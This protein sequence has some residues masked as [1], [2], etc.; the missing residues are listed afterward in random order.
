MDRNKNSVATGA[1]KKEH[2][3]RVKHQ[4]N[5]YYSQTMRSLS[6]KLKLIEMMGGGCSKCGYKTNVSALHFHHKD[7]TEKE[8]KLDMRVLSNRRWEVILAEA[9]KCE[10]LC[11]NCHAEVHNPE[12]SLEN[13]QK[14]T[15][16]GASRRKRRDEQGV[17]S[18]KP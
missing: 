11:A 10:L 12:L 18:G 14:L 16:Q 1:S 5:T 7:H 2:Y 9:K 4:T 13:I 3:Y 15:T 6:R 8:I 17:N